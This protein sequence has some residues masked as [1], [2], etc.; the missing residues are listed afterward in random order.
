MIMPKPHTPFVLMILDGWGYG[1]CTED[2]AIAK[3]QTPCW[4]NLW[5]TYPHA[6]LHGS[7]KAVGL[8]QGQMG[9]SEVGH[10]NIGAGRQVPQDY[11][12]ITDDITTG[13]FEHNRVLSQALERAQ[14]R[15]G[16]L[17]I[18][19]LVSDGG[20]HSHHD[21]L[22]ALIHL[23]AKKGFTD[24]C[25]HAFLDGRDTAP[26]SAATA[27]EAL[28]MT[29]AQS[30]TGRIASLIGRYYAMDRDNRWDRVEKAYRLIA[31]GQA[32]HQYDNALTA[33]EAAYARGQTDEFVE[34]TTIGTPTAIAEGDMVIF[35]NFR[36]DRA[37]QL[38][39]AFINPDF[40]HFTRRLIALSDFITLTEY[41]KNTTATAAYPPI[42][43]KNT[44]GACLSQAGY[45]QLRIA[46]TEKYAHVTFFFNGGIETPF[47]L[48][49]R[50]L[51]PSPDVKTYDLQ[52]QM[53]APLLTDAILQ[54]IEQQSYDVIICNYANADMVGH[55]G[56]FDA[57]K[58]AIETLDTCIK[59]IVQ[60]LHTVQGE[61]LIT[62]DHGN[63]EKMYDE[64]THQA[65][66]AHTCNP[67]PFLYVGRNAHCRQDNG[68][69]ADIAP[70]LLHLLGLPIAS[71]MTGQPLFAL[72]KTP[73]ET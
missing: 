37:R 65:H 68:T 3:A 33:L 21:H 28:Q 11:T 10:L 26:K 32:D 20:V 58:S 9:N 7:G 41:E 1:P 47:D 8:P 12:R 60:A 59:R 66:T 48:E 14:Q 39:Q 40:S 23:A 31:Q 19:G 43:L 56:D 70:T 22:H 34:P 55:T 16:R 27:L 18:M 24:C 63:A 42:S 45:R 46:E 17:H 25:I 51:I 2:N 15:A 72:D 35:F 36:A 38:T 6:L 50:Q 62:A 61:I 5:Q 13:A 44:L 49:T 69:L 54:A 29:L 53:S 67:V 30:R 57:T 71:E 4:D 52:P 64:A 73:D